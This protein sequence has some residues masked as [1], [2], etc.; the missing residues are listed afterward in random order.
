MIFQFTQEKKPA[1][2]RQKT[3]IIFIVTAILVLVICFLLPLQN[4]PSYITIPLSALPALLLLVFIIRENT[5]IKKVNRILGLQQQQLENA[6][7]N[8]DEGVIVTDKESRIYYMNHAAEKITGHRLQQVKNSSLTAIYNTE[9]E[10]TG[11]A[12]ENAAARVLR[13]GRPV[14][15]ENNTVIRNSNL[16]K[17]IITN[18]CNP[19]FDEQGE[20]CGTVLVF[21]DSTKNLQTERQL[22]IK[23]KE[24]RNLIQYLPQAVY[25]CDEKGYIQSYNKAA[26]VLWGREPLTGKEKWCGAQKLYYTDGSPAFH[27]NSPL[28]L[29]VKQR[30]MLSGIELLVQQPN[31]NMRHVISHPTPLFGDN[32]IITGGINVLLD[33]TDRKRNEQAAL[34]NEDKYRSLLE[35]ASEAIFITDGEGSFLEINERASIITGYSKE[36]FTK[37][38]VAK[39]FPKSDFEDNWSFF[40]R[41]AGGERVVKEL[42]AVH[43]NKSLINVLISANKLSD[44]RLMAI[45]KDV[46][47]LKQAETSLQESEQLNASILTSVTSHIAV[48]NDTGVVATTNKAWDDF[49]HTNGKT[50]LER[51]ASGDNFIS[52]TKQA[53]SFGD[54]TSERILAGINDVLT[55][56]I[57]LFELEYA[58]PTT[59]ELCWFLLRVSPFAGKASKAVICHVDIT[60]RKNAEKESGNYRFALDQSSIVDVTDS[61]GVITYVNNNFCS[62]TGYSREEVLG[63][64]HNLISSGYHSPAF[65]KKLWNTISNGKVWSGEIK[66]RDKQ[67][68]T[69]WV[70]TTIVPFL[71]N[72]GKPV[73]FISIRSDISQR[74]AAEEKMQVAME[75]FQFLSHAT[76][77]TVWDW[78]IENDKMLYNEGISKMLGYRKPEVSN[79]RGWWKENIHKDDI[80]HITETIKD[81]F[82]AKQQVL[83]FEYRF[84][85]ENGSYKYIY[86]RAFVLYNTEGTAYRMIGAMQDITY[87][88]EEEHRITKAIVDAQEAERQYLGMELHDNINQLLTGSLLMLGAASHAPMKKEDIVKIVDDCKQHLSAAVEEIRNLSHRLAPAAFTNSLQQECT[89]LLTEISRTGHFETSSQFSGINERSIGAEIKICLYRIL[90]EQLSNISKH[91]KATYVHVTMI[92]N[93]NNIIL[94]I[95]DNGVG[96]NPKAPNGGIGLGN[97]KKRTGYFSGRFGLSTAPGKGCCIEVE[98]PLMPDGI[99]N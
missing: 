79:I 47:E 24:N 93:R 38:N 75:R 86:D 29:A 3:N 49:R 94:K 30:K 76:S 67:G 57:P 56:K 54:K 98:I 58:C 23:E 44:G 52:I 2:L 41:V 7:N 81:A 59:E 36:E 74:K 4:S 35:Q 51:C 28:A 63:K 21:K 15:N 90:Q 80:S 31:G 32:G 50:I 14:I 6:V 66:N 83:Q 17:I 82:A 77:D 39:L 16:E 12:V 88:K 65:Y 43:K 1:A 19:L 60:K 85:C 95:A 37:M 62:T 53:A 71:N 26:V 68:N 33:I 20:I 8:V 25:T 91:S 45:V 18:T 9:N 10:K 97:I 99:D 72:E 73:Q 46:T 27:E 61:N 84:R 42:T 13:N 22:K 55:K 5:K 11:K 87:K 64:T 69:L 92:Q 89:S 78:D 48:I 96:F 40:V 34:Y 70:N